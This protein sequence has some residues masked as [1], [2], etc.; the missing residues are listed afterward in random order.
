VRD[1][2]ES[3]GYRV[4]SA[5]NGA[6][7]LN[8]YKERNGDIDLVLLDMV[9]PRMGGHETFLRLRTHNPGVKALLCTGYSEDGKAREILNSGVMGFIQKP[10]QG[11]T[12]LSKVRTV[13]DT[14]I[15]P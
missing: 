9:M 12:L 3:N 6:E 11:N 7:A 15:G 8:V 4:L 2:L 1:V 5:E 13:L 14:R 10:Y